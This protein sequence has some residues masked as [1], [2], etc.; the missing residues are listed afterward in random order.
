MKDK[1][2][3]RLERKLIQEAKKQARKEGTSVS[4]MVSDYFKA[5]QIKNEK[6]TPDDLPPKTASLSGI[7]KAIPDESDYKKHLE[8]KYLS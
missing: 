5:L 2:T 4:Q 6:D 7:I 8:D 3:L 1:L